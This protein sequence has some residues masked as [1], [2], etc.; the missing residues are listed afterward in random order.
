MKKLMH[1]Q[2]IRYVFFGGCTTFVNLGIT[3][4]LQGVLGI[5]R[6]SANTAAVFAAILFAYVVNKLFVFEHRADSVWGLIKEAASFIGMRLGTMVIEVMGMVFMAGIW[7]LPDAPSKI[8]LQI[9]ILILNYLISK[10]VVFKDA[11]QQISEEEK[12]RRFR[13][14]LYFLGGFGATAVTVLAGFIA[15]GVWP[16]GDKTVLIVDSLHQYLPFYTDFQDKLAN[17]ESLLF[18]FAGGLGYNFWS[19]IAYYLASPFNFLMAF[20]PK[21]NVCDFMD[22]SILIRVAF[23]GGCFSWYLHDRDRSRKYLPVVFGMFFALNNYILGYYFNLMWIDSIAVLPFILKGIERITEEKDGKMYCLS[24]FYALWCNYYIGFMLCIFS[25]LYFLVRHVS[26][27]GFT[28]GRLL[29][30]GLRFTWYS[31]L[32]G[33]MAAMMLLPAFMGLSLSESVQ[34]NKFPT[35]IKFYTTLGDM[36]EQHLAFLE[37]INISSSQVGLNVYCGMLTILCA[38]LYLFQKRRYLRER[39]AHLMLIIL[40]LLS[41]AINYLNYIWHGF[42]IQNGL[43]NRFA[44]LYIAVLLIMAYDALEDLKQYHFLKLLIAFGLTTGFFVWRWFRP[45]RE[46]Q[47]FEYLIS[48]GF[49]LLYFTL[50]LIARYTNFRNGTV[51]SGILTVVVLVEAASNGIYGMLCDGG[52]T[53]SMYLADQFSYQE[54][55]KGKKEE[56]GFFR[57]EVDRQRMRN[58]TMFVGGNAFVMFNSTMQSSF[59]DFCDAIG[60]EAR[61]N[62]NGYLGVTRLMNDVFGIRYLASPS[63]KADSMYGFEKIGEDGELA[64]YQNEQALSLGFMV[65]DRILEWIINQMEPLDVQNDFVQLATG[66]DP[67][68]VLDRYIDMENGENY[69]IKIPEKKQV[70]LCLDTRIEKLTLNTPEYEKHFDDYNDHLYP[71]FQ[72]EKENLADFTSE[73]KSSQTGTVE[74]QVYTCPDSAYME[75]H[76]ILARNQ[77]E[78]VVVD[79]NQISGKIHVDHAG[80]LL[81]SM[82]HDPGWHVL[83][84]GQETETYKVGDTLLGIHLDE[85]DFDIQ[86]KFVPLGLT[87]GSILS[88]VCA[89]LFLMTCALTKRKRMIDG[90]S[91][92]SMMENESYEEECVHSDEDAQK[93]GKE[94]ELSVFR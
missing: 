13:A 5:N 88:L 77:L 27:T 78:N 81:F 46:T 59:V 45:E 4:L 74:A 56:E 58:V 60:V 16:F 82:P 18:S 67:I 8:A 38:V 57:S 30:S 19:T 54:L 49:L 44:F 73:L 69:A 43:P 50:L 63:K 86:M 93:E 61:T 28:F 33:G 10:F 37:P 35:A 53:R 48:L 84:N 83:V 85:G 91:K 3:W 41:F 79:G 34:G 62:K 80:T 90:K 22:W 75:V 68:F 70:Y 72:T 32:S 31:L 21:E 2:G 6:I 40:F 7:G 12:S 64:L 9:I 15:Y 66:H 36:L 51:L 11:D 65:D 23:C 92:M 42:H 20:I 1:N 26:N 52:V 17:S 55:M 29:R 76:D 14:K 94:D 25:C 71:I 24:L 87:P 47:D 39:I 89:A